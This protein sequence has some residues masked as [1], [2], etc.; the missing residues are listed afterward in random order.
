MPWEQDWRECP[1][2]ETGRNALGTRLAG[3]PWEQDLREC[4]G[5]ETGG[6]ALG[7]RLK[8]DSVPRSNVKLL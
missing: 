4:P 8:A 6:N 7:T 3:M 1:G 2:N 5:N